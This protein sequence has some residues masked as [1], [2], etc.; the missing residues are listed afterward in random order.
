ML[1]ELLPDTLPHSDE[2]ERAVLGAVLLD[3]R[4][5][6]KAQDILTHEAFYSDRNR[7]I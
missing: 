3:N 6:H 1:Q 7:R 5:L 4:Q 2:A